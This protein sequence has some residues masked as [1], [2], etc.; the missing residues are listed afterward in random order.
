VKERERNRNRSCSG[1]DGIISPFCNSRAE[2]GIPGTEEIEL[3]SQD[4]K[5]V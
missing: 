1:H 4:K 2:M 3:V 5:S